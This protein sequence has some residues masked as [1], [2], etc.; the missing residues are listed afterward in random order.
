MR[1]FIFF[2][3]REL[4]MTVFQM[5]KQMS[6]YELSEWWAY[7]EALNQ[8]PSKPLEGGLKEQLKGA[9]AGA[10]VKAQRKRK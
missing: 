1:F 8:S 4:K 3:A 7:F 9:F 6:S 2:L 5:T 10:K